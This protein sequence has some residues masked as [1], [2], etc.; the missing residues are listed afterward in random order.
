MI[1]RRNLDRWNS[2]TPQQRERIR[3]RQET[4]ESLS[5]EQRREARLLFPQ[6]PRLPLERKLAVRRGF[7]PSRDLPPAQ[8]HKFLSSPDVM[9]RFSPQELRVLRGLARLLP[10][11]DVKPGGDSDGTP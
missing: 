1:I 10:E 8:R 7:V 6:Y 9:E 3:E 5:P 2:P 4:L 11:S